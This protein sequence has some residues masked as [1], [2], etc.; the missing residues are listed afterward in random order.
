MTKETV[1]KEEAEER[2]K[3]TCSLGLASHKI[4]ER[5]RRP[6]RTSSP[7]LLVPK[8]IR[9]AK[10]SKIRRLIPPG[11]DRRRAPFF[12][13]FRLIFFFSFLFKKNNKKNSFLLYFC[14]A[15]VKIKVKA[16]PA[17]GRVRCGRDV[18]TYC[19]PVW[20]RFPHGCLKWTNVTFHAWVVCLQRSLTV[21]A[22]SIDWS[23][24]FG[25]GG[26]DFIFL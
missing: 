17:G 22:S 1:K 13:S 11:G 10:K 14:L 5:L 19:R 2:W 15:A 16:R 21:L 7:S 12:W 23:Q 20:V 6:W 25:D 9:R 26:V 8:I 24:F 3:C 18:L 4:A